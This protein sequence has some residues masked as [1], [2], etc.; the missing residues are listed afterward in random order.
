MLADYFA[1]QESMLLI[2]KTTIR[3][4]IE[5]CCTIYTGASALY[6]V[7]AIKTVTGSERER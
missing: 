2:Y 1:L 3:P 7:N 4:C 5:I 6:L